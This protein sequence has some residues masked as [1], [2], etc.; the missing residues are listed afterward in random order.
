MRVL[1]GPFFLGLLVT[2][3][4]GGCTREHRRRA[5]IL[6]DRILEF[7]RPNDV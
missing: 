4:A 2:R 3:R 5:T 6:K 7:K 1:I